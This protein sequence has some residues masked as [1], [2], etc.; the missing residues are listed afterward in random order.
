[1][2]DEE[3]VNEILTVHLKTCSAEDTLVWMNNKSGDYTVKNGYNSIRK[4]EENLYLDS[5]LT[6]YQ[7]QPYG[8]KFGIQI[9]F[10]RSSSFYGANAK[11]YAN[12]GEPFQE[13]NCC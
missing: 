12:K 2:F 1:M 5:A 7:S 11:C 3:I 13:E 9:P 8:I 4:K 10:E 6:S